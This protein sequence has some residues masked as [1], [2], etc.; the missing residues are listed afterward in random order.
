[1][2]TFISDVFVS[3]LA[4]MLLVTTGSALLGLSSKGRQIEGLT[5]LTYSVAFGIL[6]FALLG[7]MVVSLP[8][9]YGINARTGLAGILFLSVLQ[10][11]RR[12]VLARLMVGSQR[13]TL[14]GLCSW[15][16]IAWLSLGATFIP[17]TMPNPL[18]DGA[19]VIKSENLH[20]KIQR[21]LGDFPADNYIPFVAAEF[22]LRDIQFAKER[23]LM[24]G[25]ELS[26]R[27][28]LLSLAAIPIHAALHPP[29]Q[30]V[31]PLPKFRYVGTRW[32]NVGILG[33]DVSYR[34]FLRL[35]VVFNAALILAFV[36]VLQRLKLPI[37]LAMFSCVAFATSP[38]FLGQTL[39]VWPKS[40][41]GFFLIL[42]GFM[43]LK[44][45]HYYVA[46]LLAGAAY[47]SHPYAIVYCFCFSLYLLCSGRS[48]S[49]MKRSS[50]PFIISMSLILI[51]WFIWTRIY[52]QIPSDL[53][54]QNLHAASLQDAVF[55]R[56]LN[57][58]DAFLPMPVSWISP[59]AWAQIAIV[60]MVGAVG[61]FVVVPALLGG[62]KVVRKAPL[63][64]ILLAVLPCSMLVAV[65]GVRALPALHG[66]QPLAAVLLAISFW[67]MYTN[68]P[69]K[70]VGYLG[71][72]QI[73]L[74][75]LVVAFRVAML[76]I[77]V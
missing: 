1:L 9:P 53:V 59:D 48:V 68:L 15:A 66:L 55:A 65:F 3:T 42:S 41:A 72:A 7:V 51:P 33:D 4:I 35:A 26:N 5:L 27:P 34:S 43:L 40:L 75:V 17:V 56:V 31:E 71:I 28:I 18:P 54:N 8:W 47:W 20:V 74:N 6:C 39:F 46:G 29:S 49:S 69:G 12:N 36:L 50:I 11:W 61:P 2:L 13:W 63:E 16:C 62:L 73:S 64:S 45:R 21:I 14:L 32:P 10:C 24:P 44:R 52:L 57:L 67:W 38:Y 30:R 25:Q 23:P 58:R 76:G 60:G 70:V 19:Y 37:E 22:L 77:V